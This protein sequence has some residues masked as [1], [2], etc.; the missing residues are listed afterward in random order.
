MVP[1]EGVIVPTSH[2]NGPALKL[3][4][5]IAGY[6]AR[7]DLLSLEDLEALLPDLPA[8]DNLASTVGNDSWDM[9]QSML[10]PS[11]FAEFYDSRDAEYTLV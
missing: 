10:L 2:S 4:E 5:P 3:C 8:N 6:Q 9:N 11:M 1:T 7:E